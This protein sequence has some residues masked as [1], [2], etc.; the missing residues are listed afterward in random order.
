MAVPM[1]R[2]RRTPRSKSSCSTIAAIGPPMPNADA[3]TR[4]P[5]RN[6]V[7]VRKPRFSSRI[8]GWSRWSTRR[9]IRARSPTRIAAS[10]IS[11]CV[12]PMYQARRDMLQPCA[13]GARAFGEHGAGGRNAG[14]HGC[15]WICAR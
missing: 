5:P 8:V 14:P 11:S 10:P 9:S 2:N 7:T 6:P 13:Q 3:V 12:Q 15:R 4:L 1:R